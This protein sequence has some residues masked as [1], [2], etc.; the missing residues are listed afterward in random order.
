WVANNGTDTSTLYRGGPDGVTV[1]PLVVSID[2]GVPTGTV[3]N[4]SAGGFS[5][6]NGVA[7]APAIFLFASG[8]GNTTA[9][10]P[11]V[12][13]AVAV[14]AAGTPGASY[15]GLTLATNGSGASFLYATNFAARTVDV[16]DS[17]FQPAGQPGGFTDPAIP[18]SFAPFGIQAIGDRIFVTYAK[19]GPTGHRLPGPGHGLVDGSP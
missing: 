11:H 5:V 7:T 14:H 10:N 9:W 2:G 15:K 18:A 13:P 12:H 1:V 16:W 3:F 8:S 19:A 17:N 4:S 6:T